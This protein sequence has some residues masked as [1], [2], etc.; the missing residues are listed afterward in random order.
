MIDSISIIDFLFLRSFT[1]LMDEICPK[2]VNICSPPELYVN[3]IA[4]I[5]GSHDLASLQENEEYS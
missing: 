1:P 4:G 2:T 3:L 5:N